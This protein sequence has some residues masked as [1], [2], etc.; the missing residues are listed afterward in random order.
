MNEETFWRVVG[1]FTLVAIA[2]S[3]ALWKHIIED[4]KVRERIAHLETDNDQIKE[5]VKSLRQRL[6]DVID[7]LPQKIRELLDWLKDASSR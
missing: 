4:G 1:I 3:G 2:I 7:T 5:E 6:H